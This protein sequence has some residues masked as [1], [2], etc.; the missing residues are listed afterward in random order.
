MYWTNHES[1]RAMER[2]WSKIHELE[3]VTGLRIRGS[4]R[5]T[6]KD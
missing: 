5:V 6:E 1:E 2:D 4:A 3:R